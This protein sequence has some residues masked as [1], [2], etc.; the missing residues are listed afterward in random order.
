MKIVHIITRL[1]NGGADENT[2]LSCNWSVNNGDEV[3]LIHGL[4]SDAEIRS[5]LDHRVTIIQEKNLVREIAPILDLRAMVK[6][7]RLLKNIAPDIVHTHTS[8]AGI[9][10]RLAAK[11]ANVPCIIHG[12]HIAPFLN[13]GALATKIY[14]TLEKFVARW[15]DAFISV[16]VG[17]RDAYIERGIGAKEQHHIFPSGME[18][19][20]FSNASA[21]ASTWSMLN[22]APRYPRPP[23]LLMVAALEERKRHIEFLQVFDKII[24]AYPETCLILAGDGPNR[25]A[26]EQA[27][28][29]TKA[30]S[31]IH[32]LG[33]YPDP[34]QLIAVADIGLLCSR[35]E[36]LPRVVIQYVAGGC[37]PVVSHLPGIEEIITEGYN[38][39]IAPADDMEAYAD[40]VID[41]LNNPRERMKLSQNCRSTDLSRWN[42]HRMCE[43]QNTLYLST[44]GI[45]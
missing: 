33:F 16:S 1:I 19:D 6:L 32:L 2:V 11:Q 21:H 34:S 39:I 42:Y 3:T 17:M 30:P 5:K 10:G 41:I 28:L 44:L 25:P 12:I 35:R 15:T 14:E 4:K 23:I 31:N 13:Q 27:I 24:D 38:G 22:I 36:G 43:A 40:S 7:I 29:K 18:I 9:I 26:V 20:L 8:K 37:P 45:K